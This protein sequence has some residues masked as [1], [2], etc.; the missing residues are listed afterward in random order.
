MAVKLGTSP[1]FRRDTSNSIEKL[2]TFV[3]RYSHRESRCHETGNTRNNDETKEDL[4]KSIP[5]IS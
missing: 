5:A 2:L 1:T 3:S 4:K